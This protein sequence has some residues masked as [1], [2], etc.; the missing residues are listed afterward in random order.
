MSTD[1][2]EFPLLNQDEGTIEQIAQRLAAHAI[3]YEVNRIEDAERAS[4]WELLQRDR[5]LEVASQMRQVAEQLY[6]AGCRGFEGRVQHE[7][8]RMRGF[9]CERCG[10]R[11]EGVRFS[12]RCF[13]CMCHEQ[14]KGP[15]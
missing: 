4:G 11:H 14:P 2:L 8:A 3:A 5:A 7:L 6:S 13:H 10:H 12:Y 9:P 1:R 15:R